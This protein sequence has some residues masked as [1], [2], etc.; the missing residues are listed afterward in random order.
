[1]SYTLQMV[2]MLAYMNI[3]FDLRLLDALFLSY[4]C[5][6]ALDKYKYYILYIFIPDSR[7]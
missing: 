5:S 2:D 7:T 6:Q 4:Y 3:L 1:M